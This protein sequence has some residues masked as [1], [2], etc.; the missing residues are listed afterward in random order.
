M[1]VLSD[2]LKALA[3]QAGF[4]TAV[5]DGNEYVYVGD[6]DRRFDITEEL[7]AFAQ[8]IREQERA[9][10]HAHYNYTPEDPT[11]QPIVLRY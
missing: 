11:K 5:E 3:E 2:E 1:I 8:I 7:E 10:L 9:R 4:S 6:Y